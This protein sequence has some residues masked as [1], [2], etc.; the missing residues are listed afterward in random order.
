MTKRMA[1]LN[2][3]T[4]TDVAV[5]DGV[6]P[7]NPSA[8]SPDITGRIYV[9][10]GQTYVARPGSS[11]THNIIIDGNSIANA[12]RNS[13]NGIEAAV[14]SLGL[15]TS[16]YY[17]VSFSGRTTTG[18]INN[19][20]SA[21]D[22]FYDSLATKNICIFWEGTND[23]NLLGLTA[24]QAYA[25]M[26]TYGIG[27]KRAGFKTIFGTTMPAT[28]TGYNQEDRRIALNDLLRTAK[29]S[30]E[31]WIDAIADVGGGSDLGN[32]DTT[33]DTAIF[34]DGTHLTA[35]GHAL[36]MPYFKSALEGLI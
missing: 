36:A 19:A 27:R 29:A 31:S 5:W 32:I 15:T 17:N 16:D 9:G 26:K 25:N 2:G 24:A 34:Y 22:L 14:T 33:S 11:Y 7:W 10:K 13:G 1:I 3:S 12:L 35:A 8:S 28:G 30:G 23:L 20:F 6:S 18:A 4:I 21:V